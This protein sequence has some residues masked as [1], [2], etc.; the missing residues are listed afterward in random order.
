MKTRQAKNENEEYLMTV[1]EYKAKQEYLSDIMSE[2]QHLEDKLDI[3]EEDKKTKQEKIR[4]RLNKMVKMKG[5]NQKRFP[6]KTQTLAPR[7]Y[8]SRRKY[9]QKRM[10]FG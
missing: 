10:E 5:F 1:D 6:L 9:F 7:N 4:K 8:N 2:Q 3:K